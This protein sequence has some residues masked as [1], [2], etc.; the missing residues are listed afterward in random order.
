MTRNE[1]DAFT[2]GYLDCAAWL[3]HDEAKA[4]SDDSS[5]DWGPGDASDAVATVT[6]KPSSVARARKLC[7]AF[8]RTHAALL[9]RAYAT[10]YSEA[11]AGHDLFLT[12]AGH[13]AGYWDREELEVNGIGEALTEAAQQVSELYPYRATDGTFYLA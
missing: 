3:A 4:D 13:G 11:R 7:R 5:I 2:R 1:C 6:W 9:A 12:S 8:Q 10:G